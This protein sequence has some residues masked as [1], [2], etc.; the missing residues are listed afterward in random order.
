MEVGCGGVGGRLESGEG[1]ILLL[2]YGRVCGHVEIEVEGAAYRR[3][4]GGEGQDT[5]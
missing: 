3:K 4:R 5:G 1:G 2:G